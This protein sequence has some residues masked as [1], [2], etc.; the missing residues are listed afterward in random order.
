MPMGGDDG[1]RAFWR[2]AVGLTEVTPP[3]ELAGRPVRWF[4]AFDEL[5]AISIEVHVLAD[6]HFVPARLAQPG[7]PGQLGGR[8]GG[9]RRADRVRWLRAQLGPADDIRRLS[10]LPL[11]GRLRQPGRGDDPRP[12]TPGTV[13]PV[14]GDGSPGHRGRFFRSPG[15]VPLVT[16]DGSLGHQG[17]FSRSPGT[18]LPV[19]RDGSSGHRLHRLSGAEA[20]DQRLLATAWRRTESP[21]GPI[22]LAAVITTPARSWTCRDL[23][24]G[25]RDRLGAWTPQHR[26]PLGGVGAVSKLRSS[27]GPV[28]VSSLVRTTQTTGK[29]R[30]HVRNQ[31]FVDP[32]RPRPRWYRPDGSEGAGGTGQARRSG[33]GDGPRP[34]QADQ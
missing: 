29:R 23:G 7:D 27:C 11:L 28:Q 2:D 31:L 1:A 6:E 26:S 8:T 10:A 17:R 3:P 33:P 32:H 20:S 24:P 21:S 9:P 12:V 30:S 4:R 16:R 5:G 13:L 25:G 15:T 19:T 14:T 18:V 22:G 34:Q